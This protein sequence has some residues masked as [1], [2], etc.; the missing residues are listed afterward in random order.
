MA[1]LP[2]QHNKKAVFLIIALRS[3]LILMAVTLTLHQLYHAVLK[4]KKA[5]LLH[6][7]EVTRSFLQSDKYQPAK[8]LSRHFWRCT[9]VR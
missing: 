1:D 3:C 9:T 4:G 8:V 6:Q 7:I 2:F 5:S